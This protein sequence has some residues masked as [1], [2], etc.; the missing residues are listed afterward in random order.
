[1]DLGEF[2][3]SIDL[4]SFAGLVLRLREKRNFLETEEIMAK[5]MEEYTWKDLTVGCVVTEP[6]NAREYKTGDW[7]SQRPVV[8][9]SQCIKCAVCY[10]YCPDAA[11]HRTEEGYYLADLNY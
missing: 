10:I 11:I 7:K 6:G 1:L 9:K 8:D 5:P 2:S 4:Y 3:I